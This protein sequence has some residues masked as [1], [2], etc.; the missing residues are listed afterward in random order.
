M[1]S[2]SPEPTTVGAQPPPSPS[3]L[4]AMALSS[5]DNEGGAGPP[6]QKMDLLREEAQF[7]LPQLTNTE[8]V[9]LRIRVI[10]MENLVIA[11]LA[12]ASD[13]QLTLAREMAGYISPRPG[14]TPHTLTIR[15]AAQMLHVIERAGI[16]R[17]SPPTA[18]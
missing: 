1:Q 6:D 7:E 10:A 4:R 15:A 16:F 9:Q 17:T 18:A 2:Q 14:F 3:R 13:R 11:L 8:W 12:Q 5:W